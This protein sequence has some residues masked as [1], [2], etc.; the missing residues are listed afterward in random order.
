[1]GAWAP[2][3]AQLA[4]AALLHN[5]AGI[6]DYH[7]SMKR[8]VEERLNTLHDGF[9]SMAAKGLPVRSIAPQG[10]IYLS[11]HFNILGSSHKGQPIASDEDVR[12]FLLKEAGLGIVPFQAFGLTQDTGWMR[13]SVGAVSIAAIRAG[14]ERVQLALA[15][16]D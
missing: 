15:R 10:A 12:S 9:S 4:T 2:R 5:P 14:L 13:F 7:A 1:M 16:L 8:D 6:R 3:P 11:V